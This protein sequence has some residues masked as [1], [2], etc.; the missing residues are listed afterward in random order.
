MSDGPMRPQQRRP[1]LPRRVTGGLRL[2]RSDP[3]TPWVW[4]ATGWL[5]WFGD[6][7]AEAQAEGFSY[8]RAGQV[9][10]LS[11]EP[12][13]IEASVQGRS[14][15]RYRVAIEVPLLPPAVIAE[16]SNDLASDR[17]A[18]AAVLL[19]EVPIAIA[20]VLAA[21]GESLQPGATPGWRAVCSCG[22]AHPC[23]HLVAVAWLL[24]ERFESEHASLLELRGLRIE[25]LQDR[26]RLA[27]RGEAAL[28]EEAV[29]RPD[30]E[31][32]LPTT[33]AE[34]WRPGPDLLQAEQAPPPHHAPL[35]LLRRLGPSSMDG[36]F[37][38]V[39]LLAS[40]YEVIAA[41]GTALA[42]LGDSMEGEEQ[43][44]KDAPSTDREA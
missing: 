3:A 35:A 41:R 6:A 30:A 40:A 4:P 11:I 20:Q 33:L 42:S 8:A 39:G 7:S 24:Q 25:D 2:R 18:A 1:D 23:K 16:A 31:T 38:L 5:E 14:P 26:V 37:P 36:R 15:R 10:S 28:R 27:R 29:P 32:V 17:A 43:E 22:D 34:F 44:E 19:G 9:A 13:G 21:R 12:G